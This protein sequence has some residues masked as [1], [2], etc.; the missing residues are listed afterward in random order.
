VVGGYGY[1]HTDIPWSKLASAPWVSA[2]Y[3]PVDGFYL[4]GIAQVQQRDNQIA[5]TVSKCFQIQPYED[6]GVP[7]GVETPVTASIL[8]YFFAYT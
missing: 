6:N 1:V 8:V 5:I 7:Q 3:P 4:V 2:S